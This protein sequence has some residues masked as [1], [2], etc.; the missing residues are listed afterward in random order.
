MTQNDSCFSYL[1]SKTWSF[2]IYLCAIIHL[3]ELLKKK[4]PISINLSHQ[5]FVILCLKCLLD[6]APP[7]YFPLVQ[8][9]ITIN[10]EYKKLP[11]QPP[12]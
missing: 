10:L 5:V 6:P 1:V 4:N 8:A 9:F 11:I 7:I 2:Y 12:Y 3:R